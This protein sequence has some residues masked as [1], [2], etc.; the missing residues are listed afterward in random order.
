MSKLWNSMGGF[1]Q[2]NSNSNSN[3]KPTTTT[4]TT[5]ATTTTTCSVDPVL[6]WL[7]SRDH[8]PS[9][10]HL[11]ASKPG[12]MIFHGHFAWQMLVLQHET[13]RLEGGNHGH[14]C[15]VPF[16]ERIENTTH[17]A[18]MISHWSVYI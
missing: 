11:V 12:P 2:A 1:Q 10:L 6:A 13:S 5:T 17:P 3:S 7:S 8:H 14:G 15:F 4:T 9:R 18:G 16:F